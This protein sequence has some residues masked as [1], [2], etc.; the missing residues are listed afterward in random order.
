ME[1]VELSEISV[2]TGSIIWQVFFQTKPFFWGG[3]T[4]KILGEQAGS[5][6]FSG[7]VAFFHGDMQFIICF[8]TLLYFCCFTLFCFFVLIACAGEFY[9]YSLYVYI[10]IIFLNFCI[11]YFYTFVF[12]MLFTFFTFLHF[13]LHFCT[14]VVL[15][16]CT[17]SFGSTVHMNFHAKSG[18]CSSKNG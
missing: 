13:F 12:F 16:F 5:K 8:V 1:T 4:L 18:V 3:D 6:D 15:Y 2:A 17:L 14:F 11:F 10:F 9:L 7:G